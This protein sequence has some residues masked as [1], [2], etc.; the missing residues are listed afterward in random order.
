MFSTCSNLALLPGFEEGFNDSGSRYFFNIRTAAVTFVRP[1]RPVETESRDPRDRRRAR[2]KPE[3]N[4]APA[5]K[6]AKSDNMTSRDAVKT[7]DV[8]AG[9]DTGNHDDVCDDYF[10]D[11]D[12]DGGNVDV[13][14]DRRNESAKQKRSSN[15]DSNFAT[16]QEVKTAT[17][18][19]EKTSN[20]A[21]DARRT[22][23]D[24]KREPVPRKKRRTEY[25]SSPEP[26]FEEANAKKEVKTKT[27]PLDEKALY[28]EYL[29]TVKGS[30]SRKPRGGSVSTA[31]ASTSEDVPM[32]PAGAPV[33]S[34]SAQGPSGSAQ[35]S[36]E[37]AAH[38]KAEAVEAFKA[39]QKL[40]QEILGIQI[41][42]NLA[43]KFKTQNPDASSVATQQV[44]EVL[45]ATRQMLQAQAPAPPSAPAMQPAAPPAAPS[46]APPSV[47]PLLPSPRDSPLPSAAVSGNM[48]YRAPLLERP[49][50]PHMPMQSA[51]SPG[52]LGPRPM[53]SQG[54][55][56]PQRNSMMEQGM[57]NPQRN[58][59]MEQNYQRPNPQF[60]DYLWRGNPQH[61]QQ[62]QLQQQQQ[63]Q[64]QQRVRKTTLFL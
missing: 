51:S 3:A 18:K 61:Q 20:D 2:G 31:E 32:A 45:D 39:A 58:A 5:E 11:D 17:N 36:G 44:Q 49:A 56:T 59:M 35:T 25:H 41:L 29:A 21:R 6:R 43:E 9:P 38:H 53:Q 60:N 14:R 10:D 42:K 40:Q 4:D 52:L 34:G 64:Q 26:E 24:S 50:N 54:M 55:M 28:A 48:Q 57:M 27:E 37:G 63:Y 30:G 16:E 62:Q 22:N 12:E 13:N 46:P 19:R 47:P 15:R 1:V 7:D 33:P 8:T 23:A